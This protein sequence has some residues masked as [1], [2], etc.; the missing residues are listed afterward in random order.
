MEDVSNLEVVRWLGSKMQ[1]GLVGITDDRIDWANGSAA[2]LWKMTEADLRGARL[3]D[4][5]APIPPAPKLRGEVKFITALTRAGGEQLT[6]SGW[7]FGLTDRSQVWLIGLVDQK[8]TD[9]ILSREMV[10][11]LAGPLGVIRSMAEMAAMFVNRS[12]SSEEPFSRVVE[13]WPESVRT[14]NQKIVEEIDLLSR[15][16]RDWLAKSTGQTAYRRE[17]VNLNQLLE[18]EVK[19]LLDSTPQTG[20]V[21]CR[22]DFQPDLPTMIGL[23]TDYSQSFRN[24]IINAVEAMDGSSSKQLTITTRSEKDRVAVTV[25]DNGPGIPAG[26]LD[27]IFQQHFTTKTNRSL[28]GGLGLYSVRQLLAPYGARVEVDSRPGRTRITVILPLQGDG[29]AD[30]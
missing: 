28:A 18:R 17:S 19:F 8:M 20:D 3:A 5:A 23:Y 6:A 24:I 12:R 27:M 29:H 30:G 15:S 10:H 9:Q 25:E 7:S 11:N 14:C 4:L 22:L 21:D 16:V 26:C 13:S 1:F 2:T